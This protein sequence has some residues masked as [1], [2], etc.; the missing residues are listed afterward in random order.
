MKNISTI[1][2]FI[3]LAVILAVSASS[4]RKMPE[5]GDLDGQWQMRH[6]TYA[7][8]TG[9]DVTGMYYCMFRSVINLTSRTIGMQS[10]NLSCHDKTLYLSFPYSTPD[11]LLP[12]AINA[13][14]TTFA[15]EHLSHDRMVLKSD[16]ATI[17]F[18]KF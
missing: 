6:V 10:G 11:N 14:E 12:W 4:C 15:I 13:T 7:D 9:H 18:R 2:R 1:S 16:Y 8:G 3:L 5:N 17:E